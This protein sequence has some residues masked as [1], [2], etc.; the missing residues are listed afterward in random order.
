MQPSRH[1]AVISWGINAKWRMLSNRIRRKSIV[2][3]KRSLRK[4]KGRNILKITTKVDGTIIHFSTY[5]SLRPCKQTMSIIFDRNNTTNDLIP[6]IK[7]LPS[8]FI[9][10]F[11]Y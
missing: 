10:V 5:M 9:I 11:L 2:S 7:P 3:L 6:L 8:H 4:N 1:P